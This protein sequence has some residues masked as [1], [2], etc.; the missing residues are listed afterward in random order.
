M[1]EVILR[2]AEQ[3]PILK[4]DSNF[5]SMLQLMLDDSVHILIEKIYDENRLKSKSH[6]QDPVITQK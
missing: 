2:E 4:N 6:T 5:F 1:E 3:I